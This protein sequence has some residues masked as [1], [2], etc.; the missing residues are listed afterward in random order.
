MIVCV[1]SELGTPRRR[2]R[3]RT[4]L[5]WPLGW[6]TLL[7]YDA[8]KKRRRRM[9]SSSAPRK[10]E[11][12]RGRPR[13]SPRSPSTPPLA[14]QGR[15]SQ[16][17]TQASAAVSISTSG[18]CDIPGLRG[19]MEGEGLG[20]C[21]LWEVGGQVAFERQGSGERPAPTCFLS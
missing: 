1:V 6:G 21:R 16:L 4:G 18:T 11:G 12:C 10:C 3:Q 7:L 5:R 15:P 13:P 19:G 8:R 20:K 2:L 17:Q 14:P 9:S